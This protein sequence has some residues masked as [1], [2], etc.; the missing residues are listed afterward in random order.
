MGALIDTGV[1]IAVERGQVSREVLATLD[2]D[3]V[4]IAAITASE[5]LHGVYRAK[6]EATRTRRSAMVEALL[7]KLPVVA[8]DLRVARVHAR[9]SAGLA[10]AGANIGAHD[11]LIAATAIAHG[12]SV[13]TTDSRS[14]PRVPGLEAIVLQGS[15]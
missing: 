3:V 13:V 5:L 12:Y 1:F 15:P 10:Q 14:F 7:S 6:G 2:A 4:A 8:F 11:A 9:I